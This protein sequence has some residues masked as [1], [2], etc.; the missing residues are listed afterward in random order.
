R[1]QQVTDAVHAH[2]ARICLQLLHAGRYAFHPL[3]VAPSRLKAPINPFT[4][5][6][7]SARG[8]ERTI[9]AFANAARLAREGGYDGVEVM[10]SEGYLIN[11]FLSARTNRRND[12]WGGSPENR[13]RFAV[14]I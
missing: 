8:V 1:H 3:L 2:G 12:R 7:L 14:E 4:P 6:E 13:M 5:R 9:A 11:Q 10:G